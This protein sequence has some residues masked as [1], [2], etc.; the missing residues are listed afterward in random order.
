MV[1]ALRH[2]QKMCVPVVALWHGCSRCHGPAGT[3]H[4]K[5]L[6]TA[7]MHSQA[8]LKEARESAATPAA[9]P[10]P[11][12]PQSPAS[13]TPAKQDQAAAAGGS[14]AAAGRTSGASRQ[15]DMCTPPQQVKAAASAATP[16]TPPPAEAVLER[17]KS[18][19]GAD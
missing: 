11:Q 14:A 13:C 15:L 1:R 8:A 6:L 18:S 12:A 16:G 10:S 2:G 7:G 19:P 9:A 5:R 4:G 3:H 17:L